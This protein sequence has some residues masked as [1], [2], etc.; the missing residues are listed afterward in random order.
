M[1]PAIPEFLNQADVLP[2]GGFARTQGSIGDEHDP[3]RAVRVCIWIYFWLLLLE[4]ALRKWI[5]PDLANPLIVVKDPVVLAA[6]VFALRAGRFPWNR[7]V[8]GITALGAATF[9]VAVVGFTI[10]AT[11]GN[12]L[13]A[14]YGARTNFFYFPFIFLI[15]DVLR[16]EDLKKMGR[17]LLIIALPIFVLVTA[18]FRGS[19]ESWVNKG[20]GEGAGG[21]MQA[22]IGDYTRAAG[23]FSFNT[24]LAAFLSL[25]AAFLINHFLRG[26]VYRRSLA[27]LAA[28]AVVGSALLSATRGTT[29]SV[30]LVVG[31]SAFCVWIQPKLFKGSLWMGFAAFLVMLVFASSRT[32]R[33]GIWVLGERFESAQGL[34]VGIFDRVVV[35]FT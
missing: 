22:A 31:F 7:F 34:K 3:D 15:A 26:K 13:V 14:G 20:T 6:Y 23:I 1:R 19:P 2:P 30:A 5:L 9:A 17:W 28:I 35:S 16:P 21:Q 29:L 32:I 25:T 24:G 27:L 11:R 4:G 33:E 8:I 12:W 10:G 18:Q